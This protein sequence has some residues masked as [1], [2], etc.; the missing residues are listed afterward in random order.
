MRQIKPHQSAAFRSDETTVP[1]R[2]CVVRIELQTDS[3]GI[4][5]AD[6][7][8]EIFDVVVKPIRAPESATPHHCLGF[9]RIGKRTVFEPDGA[10]VERFATEDSISPVVSPAKILRPL[11]RRAHEI[12]ATWEV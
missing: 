9:F 4:S 7:E 11:Q 6:I 2:A 8:R 10:L 5:R 12:S 1:H 3:T